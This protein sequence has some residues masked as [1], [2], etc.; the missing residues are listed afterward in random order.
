MTKQTLEQRANKIMI[1]Q[2]CIF[3]DRCTI[4]YGSSEICQGDFEICKN[5]QELIKYE[6]QRR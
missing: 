2:L 3:A 4:D 6:K 1:Q 5:Y